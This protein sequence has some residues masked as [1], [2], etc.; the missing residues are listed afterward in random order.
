MREKFSQSLRNATSSIVVMELPHPNEVRPFLQ[1]VVLHQLFQ[2]GDV[3]LGINPPS[4]VPANTDGF[5]QP[6]GNQKRL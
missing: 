1:D 5:T 4:S 6:L 3:V 2:H